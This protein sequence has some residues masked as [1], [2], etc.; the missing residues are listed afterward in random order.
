MAFFR[1]IWDSRVVFFLYLRA[2]FTI[3]AVGLGP[4][5]EQK[6]RSVRMTQSRSVEQRR[7]AVDVDGIYMSAA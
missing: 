6:L 4:E 5:A 2:T 1:L 7:A 3:L